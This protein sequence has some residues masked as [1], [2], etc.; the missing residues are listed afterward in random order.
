MDLRALSSHYYGLAARVL[1]LW[2]VEEVV[3]VVVEVG[4]VWGVG[5]GEGEGL[6]GRHGEREE[7]ERGIWTDEYT[8]VPG[9]QDPRR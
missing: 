9:I 1:E 2:E 3:G 6:E 4:L 5:K 8:D 7:M